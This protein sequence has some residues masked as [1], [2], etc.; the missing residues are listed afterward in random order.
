MSVDRIFKDRH[1]GPTSAQETEMLGV[2][3]Y[4]DIKS[5][6]TDVVPEN[7]AIQKKLSEVLDG[8]RSEVQ[9]IEELRALAKEN[10]DAC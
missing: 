6:I 3:G 7:I 4:S 2:L 9:V 1:I 5:F 8:P 10:V